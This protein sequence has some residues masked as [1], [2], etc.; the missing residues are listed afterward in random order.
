[1][2]LSLTPSGHLLMI[3]PDAALSGHASDS[4]SVYD[5]RL[6]QAFSESQSA[7]II[8]LSGGKSS[9]DWPLSWVFWRDFG[10]RYLLQRCQSQSTTE[11]LTPL[12]SP[13][14][15]TLAHLHLSLPPMPGAEYCTPD[16]LAEIWSALDDWVLDAIARNQEGLSGFL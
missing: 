15:S 6:A 3:K 12:P 14:T 16:L 10:T 2:E 1:M 4:D 5:N 9:S 13:D 11:R 7:G 8:A